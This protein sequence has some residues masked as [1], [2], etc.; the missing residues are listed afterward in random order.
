MAAA[1]LA[2]GLCG[3]IVRAT[4]GGLKAGVAVTIPHG[5]VHTHD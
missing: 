5:H 1:I 2:L 4:P 3:C